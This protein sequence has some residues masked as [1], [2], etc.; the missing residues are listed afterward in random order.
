MTEIAGDTL[1]RTKRLAAMI[2]AK[3]LMEARQEQSDLGE[4]GRPG[5]LMPFICYFWHVLEPNT[6]LVI[7]MQMEAINA[8]IARVIVLP[9]NS[10]PNSTRRTIRAGYT[11]GSRLSRRRV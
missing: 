7:D 8:H 2:H 6:P 10:P 3:R 9:T 5:G 1:A 11:R 4:K